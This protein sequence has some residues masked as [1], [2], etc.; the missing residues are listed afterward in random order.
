MQ[1]IRPWLLIGK[2]HETINRNL[3]AQA[4]IDALLHLAAPIEPPGITSLYLPINDGEP[5][6]ASTLRRG[7]DFVLAEHSAGKIVLVACGAGIS[8]STTFAIAALKEAEER[9][10]LEAAEII[11][12]AHP[13]GMPHMALW[14]SLCMY[15]DEPHDYLELIRAGEPC[16]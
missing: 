9:S 2:Y 10:L 15:Y 6:K 5:L 8:R 3:L 13:A 11:R 14:S 4:K 7:V 16:S 12:R 1:L